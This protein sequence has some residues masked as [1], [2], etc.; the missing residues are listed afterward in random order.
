MTY[1]EACSIFLC[2]PTKNLVCSSGT[3]T[4]CSC[5]NTYGASVCDCTTLQYWNGLQCV[6]RV[7]FNA[8]CLHSYDCLYNTG[9]TC[10]GGVCTCA[11]ANTYWTGTE[12]R[13]Y[14][15]CDLYIHLPSLM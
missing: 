1:G 5:P 7:T 15:F 4:D 2:N 13:K 12:C 8:G 9:L 6:N 10:V 14:K 11:T 3:G